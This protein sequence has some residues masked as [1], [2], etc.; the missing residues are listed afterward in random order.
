MTEKYKVY[1]VNQYCK[2]QSF[3]DNEFIEFEIEH[4]VNELAKNDKCYHMR[5]RVGCNYVF[6]GDCDNFNGS[7][8]QF[9][10]LLIDFLNI[11]YGIKVDMNDISWTENKSKSGSF[12]YSIPKF[13]GSLEKIKE[14]HVNFFKAHEAIFL[15]KKNKK[16]TKVVDTCIYSDHWF[17]YPE[18]SKEGVS[19][20]KH[21]I[22]HGKM[23]DHVVEFIPDFSVCIN[24]K[25]LKNREVKNQTSQTSDKKNQSKKMM[26][27]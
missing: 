25:K 5:L 15:I 13:F 2:K 10:K 19:N 14:I 1:A 21:V 4:L 22:K 26:R 23:I 7:F 6:F 20:T 17:R 16:S 18:Q 3:I 11:K 12:H 27:I 24:D 9:A 8:D